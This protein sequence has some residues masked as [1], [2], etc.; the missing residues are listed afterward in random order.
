MTM[1][2]MARRK[3]YKGISKKDREFLLAVILSY[4][5]LKNSNLPSHFISI[6][7]VRCV[8]V[9]VGACDDEGIV[10]RRKVFKYRIR[11]F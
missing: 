8:R 5:R 3:R 7:E 4:N 1:K 10:A 9:V 2:V 11:S 6:S